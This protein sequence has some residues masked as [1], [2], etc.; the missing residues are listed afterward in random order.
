MAS[1]SDISDSYIDYSIH[2]EHITI[3]L[4]F[5]NCIIGNTKDLLSSSFD[6]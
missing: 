6:V 4:L 2:L 3:E 1:H 5:L